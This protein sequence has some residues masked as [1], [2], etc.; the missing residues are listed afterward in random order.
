MDRLL[1]ESE[2]R[3]RQAE[4][5]ARQAEEKTKLTE[6]CLEAERR[7]ANERIAELTRRLNAY[8]ESD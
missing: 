3:A 5:R 6:R 1:E 4:E 8:R 2:E 7:A